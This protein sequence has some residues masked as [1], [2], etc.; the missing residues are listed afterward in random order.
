MEEMLNM[1]AQTL[2]A[3]SSE[4]YLHASELLD[5]QVLPGT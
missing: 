1:L 4:Q 5:L 3:T 2:G